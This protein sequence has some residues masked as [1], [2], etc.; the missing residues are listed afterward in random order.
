MHQSA[1]QP[2]PKMNSVT[3]SCARASDHHVI[4]SGR[5]KPDPE[6]TPPAHFFGVLLASYCIKI[7]KSGIEPIRTILHP[8]HN[9]AADS[10]TS[11]PVRPG[12]GPSTSPRP[13]SPARRHLPRPIS[14]CLPPKTKPQ[15]MRILG[16][17][18]YSH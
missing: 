8:P 12:A 18:T 6:W 13:L 1:A 4:I 15:S 11:Q 2:K 9:S 17:P 3:F 14:P 7:H 16:S 10:V 5:P